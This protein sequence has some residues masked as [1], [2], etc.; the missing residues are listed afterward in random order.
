MLISLTLPKV[1]LISLTLPKVW[2]CICPEKVGFTLLLT[3]RHSSC[4]QCLGRVELSIPLHLIMV[5][6]VYHILY[7]HGWTL[8]FSDMLSVIYQCLCLATCWDT[9]KHYPVSLSSHMLGHRKNITQCLCLAT[10]WDRKNITQCLC[11]ATCWDRKNITQCLCLA[12]CW[13]TENIIQCL[14]LATCWDKKHYPVSLSSHM[15]GHRKTL[16]SVFV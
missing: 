11:L 3:V 16:P 12:T 1:M 8:L 6:V 2:Y 7:G 4:Y 15:L 5:R 14:C 9:G 13:D 10:C